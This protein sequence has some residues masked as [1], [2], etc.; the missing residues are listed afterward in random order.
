MSTK[1][2]YSEEAKA[3][4]IALLGEVGLAETWRRTGISKP[5]LSL[6]GRNAGLTFDTSKTM[7]AVAQHEARQHELREQLRTMLLE[8]AID[9]LER[10]DAPHIEFK[11]KDADQVTYPIAPAAA[12]QNYATSAAIMI[13]KYR[14]EAGEATSRNESRDLTHDDHEA[15][16]L[17]DV[18]QRELARRAEQRDP[19]ART[20]ETAVEGD[21]PTEAVTT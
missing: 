12:V 1:P 3:S 17:R 10:M 9:L 11:G 5:T 6:W 20:A 8:K 7:A 19:A 16:I 15:A 21:T 18:L 4:A 13:D 14:L 2:P